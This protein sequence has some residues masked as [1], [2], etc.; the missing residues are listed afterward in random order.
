MEEGRI[1]ETE[2]GTPQIC[3][4]II[5]PTLC[6][7]AL[8]GMEKAIIKDGRIRT[9]KEGRTPK[10]KIIRYADDLVITGESKEMMAVIKE[11][12]EEFLRERGLELNQDKT[13]I[14]EIEEGIDLLGFN[15][16]RKKWN[17]HKND[18]AAQEKIVIVRPST[19]GVIKLRSKIR[20]IIRKGEKID[21]IASK[22]NPILRGWAEHKRIS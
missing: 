21:Q 2:D 5:S 14:T 20:E 8:N 6:N 19:K 22:L 12:L 17:Y 13:R 18:Q 3:G 9:Q 15:I 11:V 16:S 10:I 1:T 4:G 7:I